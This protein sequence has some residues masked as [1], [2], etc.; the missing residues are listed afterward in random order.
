MQASLSR[1]FANDLYKLKLSLML[2]SKEGKKKLERT[3]RKYGLLWQ[4]GAKKRVPVD[5]A[6]LERGILA[7]PPYWD[8]GVLTQEVGTNVKYGPFLE[9]GTVRI[10]EGKVLD[11]G[12]DPYIDDTQ[13]IHTWA[14][15]EKDAAKGTSYGITKTGKTK[16]RRLNAEGKGLSYKPQEQMPFLRPAFVAIRDDLIAEIDASYEPPAQ[17]AAKS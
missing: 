11:L 14:A 9:F 8:G 7:P 2:W 10:A 3:Y 5:E 15:K 6:R 12:D 1:R 4:A 16:G 17:E 13:A